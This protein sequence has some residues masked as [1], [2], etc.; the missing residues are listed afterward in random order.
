MPKGDTDIKGNSELAREKG[1]LKKGKRHK[2]TLIRE[3][4]LR[5]KIKSIDDLKD[6][7]IAKWIELRQEADSFNQKFVIEKELAKYIHPQKR[8]HSGQIDSQI[9]VNFKY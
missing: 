1:R 9:T 5:T 8:E 3:E 2:L 4:L 6:S 7:N